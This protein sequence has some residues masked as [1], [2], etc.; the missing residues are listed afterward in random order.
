LIEKNNPFLG[1][2]F[3]KQFLPDRPKTVIRPTTTLKIAIKWILM[4]FTPL[5]SAR[6]SHFSEL[7]LVVP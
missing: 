4:P 1:V 5:I 6:F 2:C 3:P 7:T